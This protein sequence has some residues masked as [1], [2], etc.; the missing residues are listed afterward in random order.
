MEFL[1]KTIPIGWMI[2]Y[3]TPNS[4]VTL[5]EA[6]LY[7][8]GVVL[9]AATYTFT[10]HPYF[11]GVMYT[12]MKVSTFNLILLSDWHLIYKWKGEG[13]LFLYPL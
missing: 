5:T 4:E 11:F 10:H 12:G 7:G 13:G 8:T 3:F 2:E 6:Y 1:T 9:M